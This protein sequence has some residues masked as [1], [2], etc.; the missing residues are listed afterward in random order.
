VTESL[1]SALIQGHAFVI[2]LVMGSFSNAAI[3]RLPYFQSMLDRS[4]CDTCGHT[5]RPKDLIP[6]VSYAALRGR[7]RDCDSKIPPSVPLVELLGGLV[8][9][10]LWRRLVPE[11]ADLDLATAAAWLYYLVF[12]TGLVIATYSDVRHHIIPDETSIYAIPFAIAGHGVLNWLGYEGWLAIHWRT[13][14]VGCLF[15]A[16]FFGIVAFAARMLRGSDAMGWGD[17]KLVGLMGAVLGALPGLMLALLFATLIGAVNGLVALVLTR[18]RQ[19]LPFGPSLAIG[20]ALWVF[21]G[22]LIVAAWFPGMLFLIGAEK[23]LFAG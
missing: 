22:D 2:G 20:S 5:I 3:S 7:C 16:L 12:L 13:S 19:F 15:G 9:W 18:G 1:Y 6:I 8:A 14:V 11:V 4:H 23:V 10:L 17:V 21:Y